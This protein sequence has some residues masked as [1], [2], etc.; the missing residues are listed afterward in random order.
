MTKHPR[1]THQYQLVHFSKHFQ[2]QQHATVSG[3]LA[4]AM[5]L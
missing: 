4:H 3:H 5:C 1:N 2:L